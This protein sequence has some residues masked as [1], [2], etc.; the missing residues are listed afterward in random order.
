MKKL[1]R[2]CYSKQHKDT[3]KVKYIVSGFNLI[4]QPLSYNQK[5]ILSYHL[6][7]FFAPEDNKRYEDV[8]K[9][10]HISVGVTSVLSLVNV[11]LVAA[12]WKKFRTLKTWQQVGVSI[13]VFYTSQLSGMW[14]SKGEAEEF[15]TNMIEK[16]KSHLDDIKFDLPEAAELKQSSPSDSKSA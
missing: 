15:N 14:T 12:A 13:G 10:Y 3:K 2:K 6:K 9:K 7:T 16:Y 8:K 5:F 1:T 11:L 4:D